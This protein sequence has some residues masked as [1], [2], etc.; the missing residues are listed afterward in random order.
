MTHMAFRG[1]STQGYEPPPGSPLITPEAVPRRIGPPLAP[2]DAVNPE[3]LAPRKEDPGTKSP[4]E[5]IEDSALFKRIKDYIASTY[6]RRADPQGKRRH[7]MEDYD[8]ILF[9]AECSTDITLPMQDRLDCAKTV[10]QY[11]YPK[12]RTLDLSTLMPQ[13]IDEMQVAVRLVRYRKEGG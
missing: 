4:P 13:G 3:V 7:L 9:L 8:P 2:L 10:A 11:L 1:K 12:V 6:D 5:R